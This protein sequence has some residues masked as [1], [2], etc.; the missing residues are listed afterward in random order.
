MTFFKVVKRIEC[1][2]ILFSL[3]TTNSEKH[4]FLIKILNF[5]KNRFGKNT[6]NAFIYYE[7]KTEILILMEFNTAICLKPTQ[8]LM[9]DDTLVISNLETSFQKLKLFKETS[10][11]KKA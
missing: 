4:N 8:S 10:F 2:Q 3:V 5:F 1:K 9:I 11:N 6:V 7:L